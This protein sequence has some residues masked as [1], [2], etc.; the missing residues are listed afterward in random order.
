MI[1][2]DITMPIQIINI[3]LLIVVLNMY[4]YRPIRGVLA[5]REK[6]LA[7]LTRSIDDLNKNAR[8]RLE[9]IERKL[10]DAR[11]KAKGEL[12][13]VRGVAQKEQA[14]AL[15]AL[16]GELDAGKATQMAEIGRQLVAAQGE[17]KGQI[18]SFAKEIA[19]KVLGRAV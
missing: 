18:D 7:G 13:G 4:L 6:A 2:I 10:R 19:S 15:A 1:D 16:R 5:E 17:L 9:E 11:A 3:L 14:E 12:D 8:L